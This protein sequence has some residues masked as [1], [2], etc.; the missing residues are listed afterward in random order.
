VVALPERTLDDAARV[1]ERLRQ[2]I[3]ALSLDDARGE[4]LGVTASIGVAEQLPGEDL[5]ALIDR[6]DRAMYSAKSQGRDRVVVSS[7]SAL[8]AVA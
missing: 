2:H 7:P 1:A 5:Q 6:A 8:H 3:A 4:R